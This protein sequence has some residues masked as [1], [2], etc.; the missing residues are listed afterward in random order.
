[1]DFVQI[2][3]FSGNQIILLG[4]LKKHISQALH[5]LYAEPIAVDLNQHKGDFVLRDRAD[6]AG[7]YYKKKKRYVSTGEDLV[8]FYTCLFA[9]YERKANL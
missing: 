7:S 3:T 8:L 2:K 9:A 5:I 6:N 4:A 1:M